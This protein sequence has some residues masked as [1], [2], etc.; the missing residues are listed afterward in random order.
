MLSC[1]LRVRI[2][3]HGTP[4]AKE[5]AGI[6]RVTTLPAPIT[7]LSPM[8]TPLHTVTLADSYTLL[9]MRTGLA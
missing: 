2:T 5:L 9:P 7:Q 1:S 3:R 6:S 4:A 8:V